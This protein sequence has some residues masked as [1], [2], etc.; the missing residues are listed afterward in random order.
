MVVLLLRTHLGALPLWNPKNYKDNQQHKAAFKK[1][2]DANEIEYMTEFEN[3]DSI[4]HEELP[5][6]NPTKKKQKTIMVTP[7]PNIIA[8]TNVLSSSNKFN[9]ETK[10]VGN[11]VRFFSASIRD[12]LSLHEHFKQNDIQHYLINITKFQCQ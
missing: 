2:P 3:G 6:R 12:K 10:L 4:I 9:F 5:S 11:Y 8:F 7:I 1:I